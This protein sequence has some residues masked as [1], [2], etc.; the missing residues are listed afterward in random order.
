MEFSERTLKRI[1]ELNR[2]EPHSVVV[3]S[4]RCGDETY[5]ASVGNVPCGEHDYFQIGSNTKLF[6]A[7]LIAKLAGEKKLELT[8]PISRYIPLNGKYK[9]PTIEDL[10]THHGYRPLPSRKLVWNWLFRRHLLHHNIYEGKDGAALENYLLAKKPPRK[11]RYFYSDLNYAVLG[12]V[13]EKVCGQPYEDAMEAFI[14]SDLQLKETFFAPRDGTLIDSYHKKKFCGRMRWQR[15]DIYG[16]AGGLYA[17]ANDAFRFVTLASDGGTPC[18]SETLRKRR[19][20]LF[21]RLKLGIGL[22]WHC[23]INGNYFFHKGGVACFRTNYFVDVK[24]KICVSV[25]ANVL[26]DKFNNT[27]TIGMSIYK[28]LKEALKNKPRSV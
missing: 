17:T 15:G 23:Y 20:I 7:A 22:G 6:T 10:L 16:A 19:T 25:L 2:L 26:G 14:R 13:I 11:L 8:D 1:K 12:L 27:T 4:V 24:R 21:G 18:L 9:Y 5:H 28:D 3:V